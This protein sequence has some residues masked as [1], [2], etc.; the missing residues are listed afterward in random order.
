MISRPYL[1]GRIGVLI[2]TRRHGQILAKGEP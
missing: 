1:A 2:S